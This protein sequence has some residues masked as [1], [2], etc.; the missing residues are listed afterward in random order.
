MDEMNIRHEEE[1]PSAVMRAVRG[2]E[3]VVRKGRE[4]SFEQQLGPLVR[5]ARIEFLQ[6]LD[7]SIGS[8]AIER[9]EVIMFG[10][11]D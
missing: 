2:V 11:S 9:N 7:R 5:E 3:G 10:Q 6:A 4:K 8:S 1:M